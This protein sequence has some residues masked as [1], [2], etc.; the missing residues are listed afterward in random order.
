[1][2]EIEKRINLFRAE[3]VKM[4]VAYN[5]PVQKPVVNQKSE[6]MAETLEPL[7]TSKIQEFFKFVRTTEDMLPND[8]TLKKI[9]SNNYKRFTN[10]IPEEKQLENDNDIISENLFKEFCIRMQ[11]VS[12]GS[13][14]SE[15]AKRELEL[16]N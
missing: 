12:N 1:M 11:K 7:K 4:F 14:T 5:R 3:A 15:Q 9:L 10:Y 6:L 2:L 13:M 8:G 16:I